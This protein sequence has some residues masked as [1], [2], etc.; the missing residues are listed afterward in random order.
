MAS[1][2]ERDFAHLPGFA[3]W[4]YEWL[5]QSTP[6]EAQTA[7]IAR[8]L[9]S[10][11]GSGRVLDI[12][13]GPGMLLLALHKLNSA[14]ELFGLDI[15]AAMVRRAGRNLK[16]VDADLRQGSIRK[17]DYDSDFFDAITCVGSFYLWDEPVA[18]ADE[19]YRILKPGRAAYLY[20]S[21]R[22]YDPQEFERAFA[23]NLIRVSPWKRPI[24]RSAFRKQLRMTYRTDEYARI[25]DSTRF[26]GSYELTKVKLAGLPVW[27]RITLKKTEIAS[28]P[29]VERGAGSAIGNGE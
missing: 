8:D 10:R 17:T 2:G 28:P 23:A 19:I 4:L 24:S 1:R 11:L 7:E 20:E 15:S 3:A 16:G 21:Y 13:T 25:F 26:A 5:L 22:D 12:G 9:A 29:A 6:A 18:C 27:L 14:F